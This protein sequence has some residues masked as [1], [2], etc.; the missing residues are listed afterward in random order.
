VYSARFGTLDSD[1]VGKNKKKMAL[2]TGSGGPIGS[3]CARVLCQQGWNVVGIDNDMRSWFF[4]EAGSTAPVAKALQENFSTYRHASIDIRDRQ[5]I[6]DLF[7]AERPDFI[8][9]TA[10]QPSHD[11]AASVPY[12]NFDVNAVGTVSLLVAAREFCRANRIGDH[13]CYFSD[14]TKI[15]AHFPNWRQEYRIRR[16]VEEIVQRYA[17]PSSTGGKRGI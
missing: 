15:R 14:L 12:E 3:E 4:G 2:V 11:K 10:A 9:H 7:E 8:I 13:I 17:V 16:I 5:A 1:L 6:R